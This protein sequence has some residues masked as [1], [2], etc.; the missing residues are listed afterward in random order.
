MSLGNYPT[1][2]I[3]ET[4]SVALGEVEPIHS[5]VFHAPLL[6]ALTGYEP[7]CASDRNTIIRADL[8]R[9]LQQDEELDRTSTYP[10]EC[11]PMASLDSSDHVAP[12]E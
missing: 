10:K 9:P 2:Y 1:G 8:F 3:E 5:L 11:K 7:G 6:I 4:I 12:P